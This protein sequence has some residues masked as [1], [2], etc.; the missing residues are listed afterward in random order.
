MK[1]NTHRRGIPFFCDFY[2]TTL[3]WDGQPSFIVREI[4]DHTRKVLLR[5]VAT[6]VFMEL[7]HI[8]GGHSETSHSLYRHPFKGGAPIHITDFF[9]KKP[10]QRANPECAAREMVRQNGGFPSFFKKAE[11]AFTEIPWWSQY[12]G[13]AWAGICR[14]ASKLIEPNGNNRQLMVDLDHMIDCCHNTGYCLNKLYADIQHFLTEKTLNVAFTSTILN[15]A[16]RY[17]VVSL[18]Q[19]SSH[20]KLA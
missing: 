6:C 7:N 19:T 14:A 4:F 16:Q 17:I 2:A 15:S 5:D 10:V 13:E 1:F 18:R 3:L 20:Y 11:R 8:N 9:K 12:G